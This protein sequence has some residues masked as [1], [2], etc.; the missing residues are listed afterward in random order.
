M[1]VLVYKQPG[2]IEVEET[3]QG[4]T[5]S[6]L[7]STIQDKDALAAK[8]DL[9]LVAGTFFWVPY[10]G[11]ANDDMYC[12]MS[13]CARVPAP[14]LLPGI[15]DQPECAATTEVFDVTLRVEVPIFQKLF[16]KIPAR[17][18]IF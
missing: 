3:Q 4:C 2:R 1:L 17:I 18:Y 11:R 15:N 9:G 16:Q 14:V 10:G 8:Y 13:H 5:P 6:V 7:T 12:W